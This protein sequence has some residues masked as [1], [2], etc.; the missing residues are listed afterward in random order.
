MACW[1]T[2]AWRL[3]WPVS[4]APQGL[5]P[6]LSVL[7]IYIYIA[8]GPRPTCSDTEAARMDRAPAM[9]PVTRREASS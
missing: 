4:P 8:R 3:P 7:Y 2:P 9:E 5:E 1:Q 6:V